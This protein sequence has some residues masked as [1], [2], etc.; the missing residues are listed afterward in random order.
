MIS[1]CLRA[2]TAPRVELYGGY[3]NLMAS[4]GP[5]MFGANVSGWNASLNWSWTRWLG[6]KG[7]FDGHYCCT[8]KGQNEHN[9]LFGP[10]IT[11][12]TDR[13]NFFVHAIAGVSRGHASSF[14]DTVPAWAAGVGVDVKIMKSERVALRLAQ[15]D[16]LG[17][18]YAGPTQE[19]HNFR[20]SAGLVFRFGAK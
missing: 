8:G 5:G 17:T 15:F 13:V 18:R 1:P 19:Q 20:Y 12:R 7:D 14:S 11:V 16:Y 6:L 4:P 3:S 10:Q 2:Q 9:F